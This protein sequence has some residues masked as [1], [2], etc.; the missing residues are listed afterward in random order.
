MVYS[1]RDA[2]VREFAEETGLTVQLGGVVAVHSNL[3]NPAQHT[4]GVWFE[5][6]DW[7]GEL[8]Q[9]DDLCEVRFFEINCVPSES[10]NGVPD[11]ASGA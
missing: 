1:L 11:G 3:H 6:T 4:V 9:G 10:K 5:A 7:H 8:R 2:A